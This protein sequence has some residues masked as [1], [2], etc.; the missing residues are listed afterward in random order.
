MHGSKA[1]KRRKIEAFDIINYTVLTLF[2][3]CIIIPFV[4]I[5]NQS[6]MRN[7]DILT[8]GFSLIPKSISFAAYDYLL[9]QNSAMLRA[10][11]V[12]VGVTVAGT[13]L[14]VI[15]TSMFAYGL[16]KK[17]LPLRDLFTILLFITMIFNGGLIP[18]YLLVSSLGLKNTYMALI[19]PG[20]MSAWN[21]LILRNFFAAIP[22]SL[23]ESA[24][25]DGAN[26]YRIFTKIILP[27]SKAA[28]ATI[29]LFYAVGHWNSWFNAAIFI[30]DKSKWPMQLLLKEML[31]AINV[32]ASSGATDSVANTLPTESVKAAAIMITAIPII[33]VYPFI[34]KYFAKGVMVGSVKG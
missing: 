33:M 24:H 25:L 23:I 17:Q 5:I 18:K 26:E 27:L 3:L 7:E 4:F 12:S 6:L 32:A 16:S 2:C 15:V 21:T 11:G 28:L 10:F 30:T 8:H 14:N 13:L 34:Q 9:L 31:D 29:S 1:A 22:E 19:L 20:L